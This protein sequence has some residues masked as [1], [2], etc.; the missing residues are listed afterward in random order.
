MDA[1]QGKEVSALH[2]TGAAAGSQADPDEA[3]P[4]VRAS[5]PTTI[6]LR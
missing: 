3:L 4:V 5:R 1:C 2:E 6:E